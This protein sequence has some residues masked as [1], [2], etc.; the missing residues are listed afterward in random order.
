MGAARILPELSAGSRGIGGQAQRVS[1]CNVTRSAA[2]IAPFALVCLLAVGAVF[3]GGGSEPSRKERLADLPEEDRV[4]L[5]EFVA[6]I[7]LP[8]EEKLFLELTQPHERERFKREFWARRE[9]EGQP[10]PLGPGYERRYEEMRRLADEVYDGWR[11]DAG[12][13]FLLYGEP[14][15]IRKVRYCEHVFRDLEIWTYPGGAQGIG[16]FLFY[17]ADDLQPRKLWDVSAPEREI[18]A[19]DSCRQRFADLVMD[20][21]GSLSLVDKCKGPVC[22]G[23]C[24]VYQ[25][26]Q[27]IRARQSNFLGASQER[28]RVLA[29]LQISLEGFERIKDVSPTAADPNAKT[30]NA[31]GPSSSGRRPE[32]EPTPAPE[33][34]R[35]LTAE[36]MR[37]RILKLEP[38]YK[39]FLEMAGPLM[40]LRDLSQFL[41]F[42]SREK[43][44]FIRDFW[45][46]KK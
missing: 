26:Y 32:P 11:N 9:R 8:E 30:I 39:Q 41:Q 42:T 10:R 17:R 15:E 3:A 12:R 16:L 7:I 44:K 22:P 31:Q 13:M 14:A 25:I 4:W 38:K 37:D 23:A 1:A 24:D 40:T 5:T 36:E 6:P 46:Q 34:R 19:R 18:F 29:P 28:A 21:P 43:D 2:R 33:P 35:W 45:R 20:C 27:S